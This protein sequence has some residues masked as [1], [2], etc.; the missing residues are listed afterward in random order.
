MEI[1]AAYK[2]V[3]A[4]RKPGYFSDWRLLQCPACQEVNV[5]RLFDT[6][7]ENK[8]Q[9][10]YPT[11]N[12]E[13]AGLPEEIDRAYSTALEVKDVDSNAFGVLLGRVLEKVCMDRGAEGG[14]LY[15]KL[16]SLAERGEI[17]QRLADIAHQLRKLRNIG[18]HADLG[19]LTPSEIPVLQSLCRAVLEYVYATPDLIER[20]EKRL[21]QLK[22]DK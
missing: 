12:T 11:S 16:N 2:A 10:V 9:V 1:V 22:A 19:E 3:V 17:P 21:Q 20:V 5:G 7:E 14:R 4:R 13:V 15:E 18:A 6:Y 8:L